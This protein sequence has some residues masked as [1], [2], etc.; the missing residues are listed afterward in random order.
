MGEAGDALLVAER[1]SNGDAERNSDVLNRVMRVHGGVAG[2]RDRE[3]EPAV[4]PQ[5]IEHVIEERDA[6]IGAH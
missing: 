2:T 5:R 1:L 6:G 4:S 3:I